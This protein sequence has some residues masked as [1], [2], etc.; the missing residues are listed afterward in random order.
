MATFVETG[1]A[2]NRW[3]A[4]VLVASALIV[5]PSMA[6]A[7]QNCAPRETVV[8]RLAA[9]YGETRRTVG[10]GHD[11]TIIEVFASAMSG[12]WTM[13]VTT[14]DGQTCLIASGQAYETIAAQLPAMSEEV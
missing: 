4:I 14:T 11:D 6:S 5:P 10:R 13:T 1:M 3:A 2:A 7:Q 12:T 9:R 8:Q